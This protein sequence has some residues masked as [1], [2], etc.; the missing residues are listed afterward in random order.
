VFYD[1]GEKGS[2]MADRNFDC[3]IFDLDGVV[4]KTALVHARAWKATFDEY[5]KM[6]EERDGE[7]FRE[8][9]H[10]GDYLPYVDGKPRYK[11]VKSFLESR[12]INVP[13]GDPDDEPGK[14]T[15]CGIGNRK[16]VMFREVLDNEGV[17][18]YPSTVEFLK[19]LKANGIRIGVASSSK[20]CQPILQKAGLEDYFE[21]RVDGVVSAEL[22]LNGKPEGDIFVVATRNLGQDPARTVVVE[23][24][25]SGVQAGRNGG[26]GL[27]LGIARENNTEQLLQNGADIVVTDLEALDIEYIDE[28]FKRRPV[29]LLKNWDKSGKMSAPSGYEDVIVNKCCSLGGKESLITSKRLIFFLD[30]DGTLT[31][32]VSRPDLAIVSEEMKNTVEKLSKLY[33]V[34]IVS[35][36]FRKDVENLLGIENLFYA[37]SHGFDIL[38]PG[39]EMIHPE[40]KKAISVVSEITAKLKKELEGIE[41]TLVEE[42]KFSVAAH[43]RLVE[44][45]E[46]IAKIQDL[47]ESIARDKE[48]VRLMHGKKVFELLP[49]IDWDKGQA[50]RWIMDALKIPWEDATVVYIGDDVTDEF[51][52]RAIRT[53]GVPILVSTEDRFSSADFILTQPDD[54]KKLFDR[55]ID[56]GK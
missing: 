2:I 38:G 17:E 5:M 43:Y 50:I 21:T 6:R 42:K 48:E 10:E 36:R 41:G 27:V 45:E 1:Q 15:C 53:R 4:T 31:P 20:N 37:G 33:T 56:V 9:T 30:Y 34:A 49:N 26:F 14:E 24:A 11:G 28:W 52:F 25:T 51:A 29:D 47:V 54:V 46:D 35:G 32:I 12:N 44:N 3:V 8:F 16:N 7:P 40:A 13:F 22:G 55:L 19:S 39:F 23:D 18:S